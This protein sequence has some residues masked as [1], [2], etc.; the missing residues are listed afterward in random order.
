VGF[1]AGGPLSILFAATH[2]EAVTALVLINAWARLRRDRDHP[3]GP[4]PRC[5]TVSPSRRSGTRSTPNAG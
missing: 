2:P 4:P 5:R 3:V 1:G